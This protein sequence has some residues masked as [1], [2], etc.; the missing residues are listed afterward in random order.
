MSRLFP[1]PEL[2]FFGCQERELGHYWWLT[3]SGSRRCD[4][5]QFNPAV[6]QVF[7]FTD[8]VTDEDVRSDERQRA[9]AIREKRAPRELR[10]AVLP[11]NRRQGGARLTGVEG[12]TYLGWW[13]Y[14]V[15]KRPGS[16][17]GVLLRG[18]Y[19]FDYMR[20]IAEGMFGVE[21]TKGLVLC[22]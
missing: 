13:D 5:R 1:V 20:A 6:P 10:I 2:L 21:R 19:D 18:E 7:R 9:W 8:G 16:N 15:D 3:P 4:A 12:W 17:S 14:V 22:P 11:A